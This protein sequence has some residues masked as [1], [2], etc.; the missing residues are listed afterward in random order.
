MFEDDVWRQYLIEDLRD[1]PSNVFQICQYGFTEIFNNVIDHAE[2]RTA[3][4]YLKKGAEIEL[5][6]LDDGIGIFE[7]IQ[8]YENLHD[9]RESLL[10]LSKGKF[11]TDPKKHT[12]Q[13]IFFTSR[14][15]D[16]FTIVSNNLSYMRYGEEDW[17]F[18][19]LPTYEP[20]TYVDMRINRGS[21]KTLAEIFQRYTSGDDL[22]F[23]KTHALVQLSK[24]KDEP[25][26]S[27][28]QA[29]RLLINLEKFQSITLDFK[30]VEVVGQ[31]FVDEVFRV[32]RNDHPNINLDYINANPSVEFMIK[33]GLANEKSH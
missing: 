21:H 7:K 2:A 30:D 6:I 17:F 13:E 24:H 1:L 9:P 31:G 4:L 11:T 28:S 32:F 25:Y 19:E 26:I 18:E 14:V 5:S 10:H 27:R 20:G 22:S 23:N 3:T 8:K 12:G 15:F 29:K 33:R 16:R